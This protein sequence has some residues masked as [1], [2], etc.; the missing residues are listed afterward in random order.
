VSISYKD[1]EENAQ[2]EL[3]ETNSIQELEILRVKY[4]GRKGIIAQEISKIPTLA[5]SERSIAG[6]NYQHNESD[7]RHFCFFGVSAV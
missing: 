4:L 7:L 2:R 6:P 1:I 5:F 3:K